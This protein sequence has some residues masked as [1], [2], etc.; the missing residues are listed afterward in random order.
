MAIAVPT[1]AWAGNP[2]NNGG[3]GARLRGRPSPPPQMFWSGLE[4]GHA[5]GAQRS[6]AVGPV[7]ATRARRSPA[8]TPLV[9]AT[10][11]GSSMA[12]NARRAKVRRH[13]FTA[14]R[15]FTTRPSRA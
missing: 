4:N 14:G 10:P 2:L 7:E 8:R 6:A 1:A 9:V 3:F 11:A 15:T 12:Q 5:D 13:G